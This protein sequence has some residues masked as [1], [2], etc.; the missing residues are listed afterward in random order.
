MIYL[1]EL[2]VGQICTVKKTYVIENG[3]SE[4]FTKEGNRPFVIAEI[5]EHGIIWLVPSYSHCAEY[6]Q[7]TKDFYFTVATPSGDIKFLNY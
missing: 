4:D 1:S 2:N 7:K 6:S 3:I 5:K